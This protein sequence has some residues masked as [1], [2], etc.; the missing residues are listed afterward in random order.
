MSAA[1]E[2]PAIAAVLLIAGFGL[3]AVLDPVA[4]RRGETPLFF[5]R[6]RPVQRPLAIVSL[7]VRVSGP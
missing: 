3:V 1:L 6:L 5:A 2:R 4:A 7:A